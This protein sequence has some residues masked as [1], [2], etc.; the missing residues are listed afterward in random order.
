M[1]MGSRPGDDTFAVEYGLLMR[2]GETVTS[3]HDRHL[4]GLFSRETWR[5]MLENAG[6]RVELIRGPLDE[7]GTDEISVGS[8]RRPGGG[9]VPE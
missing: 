5:R 4:E 2:D 9:D 6:Y 7:G 8:P 3:T 1:G